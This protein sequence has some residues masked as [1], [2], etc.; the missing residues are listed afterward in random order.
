SAGNIVVTVNSSCKEFPLKRE[1][2]VIVF[3][4][5]QE[6]LHNAIKHAEA[7]RIGI[8]LGWDG[9]RLLILVRDNGKGFDA[10]RTQNQGVGVINMKRR[11]R[12][13]NGTISWPSDAA[14]GTTVSI[15][16]PT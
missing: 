14:E 6:A 5:I 8:N 3:R 11:T 4:I 7:T 1:D 13:L 12:L 10:G 16:I 9:Q 15:S 2:Q